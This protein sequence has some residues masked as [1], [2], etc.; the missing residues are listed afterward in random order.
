V[1]ATEV[2]HIGKESNRLEE[3]EDGLDVLEAE[4][5]TEYR[6]LRADWKVNVVPKLRELGQTRV[7]ELTKA[8]ARTVRS[9]LIDGRVAR[10]PMRGRLANLAITR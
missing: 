5:F 2:R 7:T 8:P 9:W 10:E 1:V 6:D 3:S 4:A